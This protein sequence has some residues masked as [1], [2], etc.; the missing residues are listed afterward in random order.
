[1]PTIAFLLAFLAQMDPVGWYFT[2]NYPIKQQSPIIV[3]GATY[4]GYATWSPN[5]ITIDTPSIFASGMSYQD[6]VAWAA[7]LLTH[8]AAHIRHRTA[9]HEV[10][11]AMQYVCLDRAGAPPTLKNHVYEQMQREIIPPSSD[12]GAE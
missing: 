3:G 11:L 9:Y 10:P 12:G 7:C 5:Q 8:E 4:G 2:V 1:M 6:N